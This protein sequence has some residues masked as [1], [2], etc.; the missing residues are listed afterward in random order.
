MTPG[1]H[2]LATIWPLVRSHLPRPPAR[3]VEIGCGRVG[4]FVPFL[5][6]SGYDA[7][8]V[9]PEAPDG[10]DYRRIEFERLEL[11]QRFDAA[12][13]SSSL[14]HVDDPAEVLDRLMSMLTSG[15]ALVVVEWAWERFDED[16]ARW[17]F[18]RLGE[19]DDGNWLH[20]HRQKWTASG[21]GWESHLR[22]W[23]TQERLHSGETLIQVLDE[24][25]DR[26]LLARGPYYFVHLADTGEA[27]EQAAIDTGQIQAN[28]IEWVG[29]LRED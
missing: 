11:S 1:E 6:S 13:A 2:W 26:R 7:V 28:R 24:R 3:V 20:R 9:D 10:D 4:G 5:R 22:D 19:A 15:G 12:I 27:D 25:F 23:A 21:M 17:C 18:Q 29:A 14:H 16:T 8:G